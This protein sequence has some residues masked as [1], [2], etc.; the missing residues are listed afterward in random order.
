M[1]KVDQSFFFGLLSEFHTLRQYFREEQDHGRSHL[2]RSGILKCDDKTITGQSYLSRP[3]ISSFI[4]F[5]SV[6]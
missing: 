6:E 4:L 3:G 2:D 1:I 5:L